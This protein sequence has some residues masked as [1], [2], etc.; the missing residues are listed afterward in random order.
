MKIIVTGANG[1]L[2]TDLVEVFSK[3]HEVFGFG[4]SELDI[5]NLEQCKAIVSALKP[6]AIIHCAAF[7]AVDLAETEQDQAYLVNA[8]GSRNMALSAEAVGAKI[9]L[10]S[11]DYVFNGQSQVPY[12][13]YDAVD[14]QS[15][16]G[17]SKRAGEE[18]VMS[19]STK[20][21]IVR[22]SW[23]YG[24]NGNNFVKT[25]I[26]L[27]REREQL[28]VVNDQ[29]GSPT[30]TKDLANF[31][32][33]LIETEKFGIYHASNSGTCTWFEFAN[34]IFREIGATIKISPCITADF[35]R[36]A[37]RPAFSVMEPMMIRINGFREIRHWKDALK[38]FIE[39]NKGIL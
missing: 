22:T 13:E 5:T 24:A 19:L 1:Q 15:V 28:S 17:K 16:Y 3:D 14:P 21:F 11:T 12:R 31:L 2:G 25:M 32:S 29:V 4:R 27:S 26:K 35:P 34:A 38:E 8:M 37:P 36:P 39:V 18:L 6:D 33:V 7:T 20:Y 30:Y 23:V 10:I 9:C